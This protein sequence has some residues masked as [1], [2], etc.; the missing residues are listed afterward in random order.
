MPASGCASYVNKLEYIA[1]DQRDNVT[2]ENAP[3]TLSAGPDARRCPG[4]SRPEKIL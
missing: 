3:G 2:P 4:K 1:A